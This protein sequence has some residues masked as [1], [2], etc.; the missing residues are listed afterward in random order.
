M[1]SASF[2]KIVIFKDRN[3]KFELFFDLFDKNAIFF[4]DVFRKLVESSI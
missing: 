3:F 1:K 4:N 2:L